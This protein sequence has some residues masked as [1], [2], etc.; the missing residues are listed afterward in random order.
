VTPKVTT[1]TFGSM[2]YN[3]N[4][5]ISLYLELTKTEQLNTL[6]I[7]STLRWLDNGRKRNQKKW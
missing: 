1:S 3:P 4:D 5:S 2:G 7:T 6:M